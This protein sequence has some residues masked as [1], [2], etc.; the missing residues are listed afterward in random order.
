MW[1]KE[2][3]V[4]KLIFIFRWHHVGI[5][6]AAL[7]A[8]ICGAEVRLDVS[9]HTP[10]RAMSAPPPSGDAA[11]EA[12]AP[13][14]FELFPVRLAVDLVDGSRIIGVSPATNLSL[15]G[16]YGSLAL[17]FE[18]I[19]SINP[20][21]PG[22][23]AKI[24]LTNGDVLTGT[25]GAQKAEMKTVLGDIA[26]E[27]RHITEIR[28]SSGM[29]PTRGLIL[30]YSF[31]DVENGI[32]DQSGNGNDG[33]NRG[34]EFGR[35]Y[36]IRGAG[37][38]FSHDRPGAKAN[39]YVEM[40]AA[41]DDI[42]DGSSDFSISYWVKRN[43]IPKPEQYAS[44]SQ[45]DLCFRQSTCVTLTYSAEDQQLIFTV[46]AAERDPRQIKAAS[47][48][49]VWEHWVATFA[50]GGDIILYRNGRQVAKERV[51]V[52]TTWKLSQ[53]NRIGWKSWNTSIS[54]YHPDHC[55]DELRIY[56]RVLLLS[57]VHD[58]FKAK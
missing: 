46:Y 19:A 29:A 8:T 40:P 49:G 20:G 2:N 11:A 45:I 1:Q 3:A 18:R 14:A 48:L 12:D 58:L 47:E 44:R 57:E 4:I 35:E 22:Q 37:A 25:I 16:A 34:A 6:L 9:E 24:H 30:Y 5:L 23:D 31:E 52:Q 42:M 33:T 27:Y 28:F 43:S 15:E 39:E 51:N 10:P 55:I 7:S 53:S 26:I 13:M 36:G 41:A 32:R 54:Q 21:A 50:S 38:N 56:G 17:P